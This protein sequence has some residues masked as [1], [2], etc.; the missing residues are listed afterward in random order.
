MSYLNFLN[1]AFFFV[2]I[3]N[4]TKYKIYF[5]EKYSIGFINEQ[6]FE[7]NIKKVLTKIKIG[8]KIVLIKTN[9]IL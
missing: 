5:K 8:Y 7:K 3:K 6:K 2:K 1:T 9:N 4:N